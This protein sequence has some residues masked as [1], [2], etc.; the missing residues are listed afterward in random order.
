[1]RLRG[2]AL[3]AAD[4]VGGGVLAVDLL[5]DGDR[6]LVSEVNATMEFRNSIEVTGV[7]IPGHVAD[8]V[9]EIARC[10]RSPFMRDRAA[11]AAARPHTRVDVVELLTAMLAVP[12][13]SGDEDALAAMLVWR[14][15]DAGFDVDVDAAGNVIAAWGDGPETIA[16]VGHLDT[17]AGHDRGPPRRRPPLRSRRRRRQGSARDGDRRGQPPT[18]RRWA[19]FRRHRCGRRG[20]HIA[21]GASS[22]DVDGRPRT[23]GHSR[24]ERLGR[25]DHRLQG[26]RSAARERHPA[27]GAQRWAGAE[28]GRPLRRRRSSPAGLR[29]GIEPRRGRV[30]LHRRPR[31]AIRV[32]ERRP[33]RSGN[34][35]HRHANPARM[36]YRGAARRSL[37]PLPR[38]RRADRP[39]SGTRRSHRS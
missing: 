19:P 26:Q 10:R 36:R 14:L 35:G 9:A 7:D 27:A 24:A 5:E 4:A 12:S 6:L 34:R 20:D 25:R 15:L 28:R 18:A 2:L 32:G 8:H 37:D 22:G 23:P 30:R 3:R 11:W 13:V 33:C 17:V 21:R 39:Q 16:L 38:R 29:A 1:M 31:A